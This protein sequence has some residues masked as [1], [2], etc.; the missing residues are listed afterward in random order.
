LNHKAD[1]VDARRPDLQAYAG[2]PLPG[3]GLRGRIV[4]KSAFPVVLLATLV[5]MLCASYWPTVLHLFGGIAPS[6]QGWYASMVLISAGWVAWSLRERLTATA[7]RP[8]WPGLLGIALGGLVWFTGETVFVRALSDYAVIIVFAMA[9]L[10][11]LGYQ[12]FV[13]LRFALA[14]L[15]LIVP[16]SGPLVPALVEWTANVVFVALQASG[17]PIYRDGAYFM[18]PSGA[19]AV[20]DACSGVGFLNTVLLLAALY[21][22]FMYQ[23]TARRIAFFSG[24]IVLAVTGNWL[25]A[26]LTILIAHLSDNRFLRDDHGTFGWLLFAALL[27][28][29][30]LLGWRF[31]ESAVAGQTAVTGNAAGAP[32]PATMSAILPVLIATGA[33]IALWPLAQALTL[34]TQAAAGSRIASV[35]AQAGWSAVA[36]TPLSWTPR[37]K[38][39]TWTKTQIFE[40]SGKRVSVFIGYFENQTWDSKLVTSANQFTDSDDPIWVLAQRGKHQTSQAGKHLQV[41]TG[42][43]KSRERRLLAWRWYW[44]D[45][46]AVSSDTAA[47]FNQLIGRLQERGN[48]GAWIAISTDASIS[49][50]DAAVTLEGFMRDMSGSINQALL[51]ISRR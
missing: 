1:S 31:R 11:V 10:T 23:S 14:I 49:V 27:S 34:G 12:W 41:A 6:E 30:F 46:V 28:L 25:R 50:E 37:L 8:C 22:W 18:V 2:S 26:Y 19:W 15:I 36:D 16:L 48:G 3:D 47:R 40:K 42:I 9:V 32:R 33:V 4:S 21:V 45:G 44:T 17:V 5:A 7:I 39:P 43:I 29:Y 35:A 20:V 24:A 38:N 13:A 51:E